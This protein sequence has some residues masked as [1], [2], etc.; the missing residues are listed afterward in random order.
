MRKNKAMLAT[1]ITSNEPEQNQ[2]VVKSYP[3][4]SKGEKKGIDLLISH[5]GMNKDKALQIFFDP[6]KWLEWKRT[7]IKLM[8]IR[9]LDLAEKLQAAADDK[10]RVGSLTQTKEAILGVS[11]IRDKVLPQS[12]GSTF[13]FSRDMKINLSWNFTPYK[14]PERKLEELSTLAEGEIADD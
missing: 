8:D 12:K 11:I 4:L 6:E 5:F 3:Q 7:Q 1:N 14:R 9:D 10:V 13:Q 2:H